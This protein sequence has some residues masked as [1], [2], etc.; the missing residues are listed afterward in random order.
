LNAPEFVLVLIGKQ[1]YILIQR[2]L[3]RFVEPDVY[4]DSG[5][6]HVPVAA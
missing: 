2:T 6:S 5:F 1:N 3:S 4:D